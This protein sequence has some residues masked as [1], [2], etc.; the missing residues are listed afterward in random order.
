[1]GNTLKFLS[2]KAQQRV[3]SKQKGSLALKLGLLLGAI[4]R[5]R[6]RQVSGDLNHGEI[7]HKSHGEISLPELEPG[8]L[9]TYS[10]PDRPLK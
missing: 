7:T 6:A 8:L 3:N 1:M 2:Q 10:V 9:T 5:R 4:D